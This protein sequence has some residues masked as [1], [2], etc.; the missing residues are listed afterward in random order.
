MEMRNMTIGLDKIIK[1]LSEIYDTESKDS[2]ISVYINKREDPKF[3]NRRIRTCKSLLDRGE[4]QNF[5]ETIN[6]IQEFIKKSLDNHLAIFASKKHQFFQSVS[7]PMKVY[8]ALIV[9]SSPYIR[10][11]VR[12]Q[13][14]YES[15][16]LVLINTNYAKLFSVS[17]GKIDREK[18]LSSNIMNKHKKGGQSQARFQRLRKGAIHAFFTE[19]IE[20]LEKIQDEQI[21]LAG[22]G[23]A[24][25][26]FKEM[27]PNHLSKRVVDIMDISIDEENELIKESIQHILEKEDE[28]SS[29]AVQHLKSE[30]LKDGLAVYG[31]DETLRAAQNGQV[32]LLIVEKDYKVKGC[33]CENCQILKAGPVK[34]CPICGGLPTEADVIEEIIEFAKRT[35]AAIE[36]SSDEELHNLG[37]IGAILRYK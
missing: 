21:V 33:L 25:L 34:E 8:N 37:H 30:I 27:L 6:Q 3:L 22:P 32:E 24:K 5:E 14:E 19:V 29:K 26:Q 15:F 12:V 18:N 35:D 16:T 2:F 4:H 7:L 31:L 17:L 11:L 9:D 28:K 23:Q 36:F 20:A 10:P 1:E 13:D